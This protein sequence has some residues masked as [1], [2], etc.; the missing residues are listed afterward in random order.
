VSGGGSATVRLPDSFAE[1]VRDIAA[2]RRQPVVP[3]DSATVALLREPTGGGRPQV[4]LLRRA[5][6]M[7]FAAGAYAFPGGSVDVRDRTLADS[8]GSWTGPSAAE[9]A[10]T[11]DVDPRLAAAIVGAAV[12][13]TFEESGV[14][15]AGPGPDTIVRDVSGD[16]WEADRRALIDRGQSLAELL[17][18]RGLVLRSD[19]LRP[20]ARWITPEAEPRRFDTRFFVAALPA[21]QRTRDVGGEADRVAWMRPDEAVAAVRRGEIMMLP[22]T[23]VT[24]IE[25]AAH[26]MVSTALAAPRR[27][28][29][30]L[31][32]VT[33]GDDG[34]ALLVLPEELRTP[35][36]Q[37]GE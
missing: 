30:R 27:V 32:E 29:P 14:L 22:P 16:D 3:R 28:R 12:R 35:I 11:L 1:R 23:M 17:H 18:R 34:A 10:R 24:L 36:G 6:S 8:P 7:A 2:G 9:W 21:G 31:P 25:L 20:W 33:I 15:L 19:L 4:Y 26:D 5:K 37:D 13:E